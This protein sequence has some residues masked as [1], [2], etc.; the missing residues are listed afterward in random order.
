MTTYIVEVS[1]SRWTFTN[2]GEALKKAKDVLAIFPTGMKLERIESS[3]L[4]EMKR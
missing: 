2:P 3:P 4:V 1:A